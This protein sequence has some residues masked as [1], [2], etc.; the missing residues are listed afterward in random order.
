[1]PVVQCE[2]GVT[3]DVVYKVFGVALFGGVVRLLVGPRFIRSGT[4]F[5][6]WFSR[7]ARFA[8]RCWWI[9]L[10][11]SGLKFSG[12]LFSLVVSVCRGGVVFP[13]VL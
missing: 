9:V 5:P 8:G 3:R 1:M 13:A 11:D 6:R 10:G 7:F 12:A 4:V 2:A